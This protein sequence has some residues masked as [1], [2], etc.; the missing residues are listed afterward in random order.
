MVD[1]QQ[2]TTGAW[3]RVE[4]AVEFPDREQVAFIID[5]LVECAEVPACGCLSSGT[6]LHAVSGQYL[7]VVL[8]GVQ[9]GNFSAFVCLGIRSKVNRGS[10]TLRYEYLK[11]H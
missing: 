5:F 9:Q 6:I 2:R 1:G 8:S 10:L 11:L 3:R 4:C 7:K